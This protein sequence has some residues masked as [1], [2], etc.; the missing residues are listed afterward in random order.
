MPKPLQLLVLAITWA[1]AKTHK[2]APS[3]EG[4]WRTNLS[5]SLSIYYT[6]RICHKQYTSVTARMLTKKFSENLQKPLDILYAMAYNIDSRSPL[7]Q[8]TIQEGLK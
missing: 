7:I 5:L 3:P 8:A 4:F 1:D 2:K 6:I